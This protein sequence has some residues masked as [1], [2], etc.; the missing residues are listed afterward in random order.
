M[1]QGIRIT[2]RCWVFH[3]RFKWFQGV[4]GCDVLLKVFQCVLGRFKEM[5]GVSGVSK[6]SKSLQISIGASVTNL[7]PSETSETPENVSVAAENPLKRSEIPL[8]SF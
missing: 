7:R 5:K 3:R 8:K 4:Q 2:L 6:S 1:F